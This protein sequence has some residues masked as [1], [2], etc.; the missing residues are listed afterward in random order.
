MAGWSPDVSHQR[1]KRRGS[2]TVS[3]EELQTAFPPNASNDPKEVS[4]EVGSANKEHE[5]K[6]DKGGSTT[7]HLPSGAWYK[8]D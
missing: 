7:T 2:G 1:P 6:V 5:T 8:I 3:F 4:P